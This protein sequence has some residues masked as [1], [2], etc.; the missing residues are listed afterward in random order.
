MEICAC[1]V[2]GEDAVILRE[3]LCAAVAFPSGRGHAMRV[4]G[5]VIIVGDKGCG[6]I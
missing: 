5:L 3:V 2:V 1:D 4:L 6:G